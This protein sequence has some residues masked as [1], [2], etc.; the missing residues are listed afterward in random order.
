[1]EHLA[2]GALILL[3]FGTGLRAPLIYDD[4]AFILKNPLV[5]GSWPGFEAFL[6]TSFASQGEYEPLGTL[7]H[8][9]L[10]QIAGEEP[11]LYRLSS[12][13]L[14]WTAASLFLELFGR[15]LANARAAWAI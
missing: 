10:F 5:T 7:L 3:L 6:S 12:L 1:M 13:L 4:A 9:G 14:H 15:R 11:F 2:L 8:W